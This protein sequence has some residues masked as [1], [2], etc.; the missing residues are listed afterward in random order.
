MKYEVHVHELRWFNTVYTIEAN[1]EKEA[2]YLLEHG[3]GDVISDDYDR[4][5]EM[6]FES[7][8]VIEE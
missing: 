1:S 2:Q 3:W 8:K 4:T 7:F 6:S 5:D